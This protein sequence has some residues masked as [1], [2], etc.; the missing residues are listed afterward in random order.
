MQRILQ[1][2]DYPPES[3]GGAEVVMA[4][5][6]TLLRQAGLT[7]GTFTCADLPERRRTPLRYLNNLVAR[8]RLGARLDAFRPD[9]IHLHNFYHVLSPGI[10]AAVRRYQKRHPVRVVM[11]AH[12]YHL[13]CP[14]SG[15]NWF[16]IFGGSGYFDPARIRSWPYLL[17]RRWD[18]RSAI[19]SMLKLIQHAW[20][21]GPRR[22]QR[23]IDRLLC[24]SR[25]TYEIY[26]ALGFRASLVPNPLPPRTRHPVTRSGPLRLVFAGR[27]EPEKGL[28]AFLRI[29]PARFAGVLQVIGDGRE[30]DRCRRTC[31]RRG[32]LDRVHFCG[33]L[34]HARTVAEI[35]KAHVLIFPSRMLDTYG[36]VLLEAL[37]AGTN[38]LAGNQGVTREVV[39]GSGTGF[40]YDLDEP[41]SLAEQLQ[42]IQQSYAAGTLNTFNVRALLQDRDERRY[43]ERLLEIYQPPLAA[44]A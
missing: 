20:N 37:A 16:G 24:P 6:V 7:V 17:S 4:Q 3:G 30:L 23:T 10:L 11:T 33:R 19:H 35:A 32:L 28:N 27:L 40:L 8:A 18:H 44:C 38:I 25:F 42:R 2:N 5:T 15:G 22:R 34:S 39:A 14:N 41:A 26:T 43:L 1:I 21:Y 36:L 9:V 12:D 29:L 31:R 13:V